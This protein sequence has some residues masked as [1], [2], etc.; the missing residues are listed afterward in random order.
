[1]STHCRT[2]D[3]I[4]SW[5]YELEWPIKGLNMQA[6]QQLSA[7]QASQKHLAPRKVGNGEIVYDKLQHE[8]PDI[9]SKARYAPNNLTRGN[10]CG[11]Y[12]IIGNGTI[13]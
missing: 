13:G 8:V 5:G 3:G 11:R 9:V 10:L 12:H 6:R 7:Y 4:L 2:C 1:V